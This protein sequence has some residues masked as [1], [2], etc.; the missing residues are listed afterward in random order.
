MHVP[1]IAIIITLFLYLNK[2]SCFYLNT[3][4]ECDS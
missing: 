2:K 3:N 4:R 1:G